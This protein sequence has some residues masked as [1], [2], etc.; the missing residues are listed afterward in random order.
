MARRVFI[1]VLGTGFYRHCIYGETGFKTR[2]IQVA[3]LL[4]IKANEWSN[5]DVGLLLLTDFARSTNW[6]MPDNK[7]ENPITKTIEDYRGLKHEIDAMNLP[8]AV[9]DLPIPNGKN[10]EEMWTIFTTL[11]DALQEGDELYIDLTHAFRYLPMLVLVLTNYAKF[12]KGVTV[13]SLTYGNYEARDGDNAPIVDL[14]PIAALQDWTNAAASFI[15]DGDAAHL[16]QMTMTELKP[17]L[18][19]R[20]RDDLKSAQMLRVLVGNLEKVTSEMLTCRGLSIENSESIKALKKNLNQ[21]QEV[22]IKPIKPIIDKVKDEFVDFNEEPD[23][24]NGFN[25]AKWCIHHGLYQ[26]ATTIL[27]ES[28]VS[29][30]CKRYEALV[31]CDQLEDSRNIIST[32]FNILAQGIAE[33]NW[34]LRDDANLPKLRQVIEAFETDRDIYLVQLQGDKQE[35]I[36]ASY[37]ALSDLRNDINHNGMRNNPLKPLAIKRKTEEFY[38]RIYSCLFDK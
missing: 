12:L 22:I 14:L 1:S 23:V 37:R 13:K 25:A 8:F 9:K 15:Q 21:L 34:R 28:V 4:N 26:Q 17:I 5:D 30:F 29:F 10:E 11:Y 19:D 6:E 18:R 35:H 20:T 36:S 24:E 27:Q 38:N 2:F 16:A 3:T 7:R 33:E 31:N 32:A